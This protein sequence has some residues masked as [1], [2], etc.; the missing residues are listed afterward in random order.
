MLSDPQKELGQWLGVHTI[1]HSNVRNKK[2]NCY[3]LMLRI[4]SVKGNMGFCEH[5]RR[6]CCRPR[7]W[8]DEDTKVCLPS[9]LGTLS[10]AFSEDA[11]LTGTA[12]KPSIM[13]SPTCCWE[14]RDL[15]LPADNIP[16]SWWPPKAVLGRRDAAHGHE[17]E[18]WVRE[19][20][21]NIKERERERHRIPTV[22]GELD[23]RRKRRKG[24]KK[25]PHIFAPRCRQHCW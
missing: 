12:C 16:S 13:E 8:V 9:L 5:V 1:M 25:K 19:E 2:K 23:K 24:K 6:P 18:D 21:K 3:K 10:R 7:W 20:A 15:D 14:R 22:D 17:I 4:H 11:G